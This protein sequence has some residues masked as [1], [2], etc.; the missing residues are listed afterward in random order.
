M[1]AI[2]DEDEEVDAGE[3][4]VADDDDANGGRLT[5][6]AG[7][8]GINLIMELCC[9]KLIKSARKSAVNND[10]ADDTPK[11]SA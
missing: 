3:V 8:W 4:V 7:Q 10:Q 6:H 9:T 11:P 2:P 1:D 5:T